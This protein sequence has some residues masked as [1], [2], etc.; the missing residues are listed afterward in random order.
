MTLTASVDGKSAT[1]VNDVVVEKVDSQRLI[2]LD[3]AVDSAG[4]RY[5][6]N[7]GTNSV[8]VHAKDATANGANA[9]NVTYAAMDPFFALVRFSGGNVTLVARNLAMWTKVPHIDPEVNLFGST[10]VGEGV[11]FYN[12]P[13]TRSFGFNVRATF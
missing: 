1:G 10:S 9:T 5:V 3:V 12:M 8:T 6:T 4:N 7:A 2:Q 11:G 13:S